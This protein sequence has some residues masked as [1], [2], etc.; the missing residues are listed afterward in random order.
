MTTATPEAIFLKDYT[1][2]DFWIDTVDLQ[3]ELGEDFT[4]IESTLSLRRNPNRPGG[5]PLVLNGQDITLQSISL[6]GETLSETQYQVDET[7]LTIAHMPSEAILKTTVRALPQK[8]TSLEG[9]YKSGSL[10]CTQCEPEGFRKITYYLD[11]PDVMA[12]FTTTIIGDPEQYPVMLS[13]GNPVKTG[14]TPDDKRWIRWEDPHK[15]P[16]YLFALV[17]G[18][19]K[20]IEDTFTTASGKNVKLEIFV[21]PENIDKCDHA[22]E[23]LKQSMKWDEE[24]FGLEY[25]L[26]IY[27]IVAVNDFNMGAMENKGL[28]VFNSKYVLAR[29][30][31]ATDNDFAGIQGVIGHEYFH[32]WTGNRVTCRDWFQLSL[33]EGLTVFRDQEF[34]SDLNSR[35]VVRIQDVNLL[36]TYQ[37]PEDG[38]PMSHPIRPASYIE[39]N[40]FYTRTI[41]EKGAE[42]IRMIHTL[43]GKEKFRKGID[44]YFERHDGQAVTTDDFVLAMEDASGVDLTLFRRWYHQAGTPTL[45]VGFI[46]DAEAQTC[47]LKTW[48]SCPATPGQDTKEPFHIPLKVA[49]FSQQGEQLGL[50][51]EDNGEA[52]PERVLNVTGPEEEFVFYGVKERPIPS[53]LRGFSAPVNLDFPY[54]DEDLATLLSHDNDPFARWE[55]AQLLY[56]RAVFKLIESRNGG[57]P[58]SLSPTLIEAVRNVLNASEGE[59]ALLAQAL[60]LPSEVTLAQQMETVDVDGIHAARK[61]LQQE[62]GKTLREDFQRLYDAHEETGPYT[63]DAPSYGRRLLKNTALSYLAAIDDSHAHALCFKQFEQGHNMT[64]VTAALSALSHTESEERRS[65]FEGFYTHW[66]HD[67][68]VLDKWLT[69]QALSSR[70][71]TLEDVKALTGHEAFTIKNPNRVRSLLNAFVQENPVHFHA[72]SGAG[73]EFI[74]DRVL[75]L[76]TLNPQVAARLLRTAFT[77]WRRYDTSRQELMRAQLQ[78]IVDA[79]DLSPDVFEIASKSLN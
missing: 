59:K 26:D 75:E 21:E 61:F 47:T 46:H 77:Q 57:Q 52:L 3:F 5:A 12:T 23:S 14:M 38:G 69:L 58:M 54:S 50:R 29:P 42:V 72:S 24:V 7:T 25:D 31:T 74:A 48:Q 40:N 43:L 56:T 18:P 16:A 28:N 55:A 60:N 45:K 17:A 63:I 8:N 34:S 67:V 62:L 39:I 33:K 30:D 37:F 68:L 70:P 64:D 71:S 76:N 11:R 6:N 27:M 32:N 9:L 13:N 73:Y 1:E 19:L 65:A 78:R 4:T 41:Y 49:L 51:T 44:L 15:K 36:R 35:A 53:L 22:M 10:F 20:A 66:K 2:P 79:K